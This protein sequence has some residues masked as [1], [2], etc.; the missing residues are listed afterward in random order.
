L[1]ERLRAQSRAS[2]KRAK[3]RRQKAETPKRQKRAFAAQLQSTLNAI[4][5]YTWYATPAGALAFVN[6]RTADYLG[7][8]KDHPLRLGLDTGAAWDSH[9]PLLHPDDRDETRRVWSN[10]LN[11]GSAGE[12]IFRV[13]NAHGEYRWFVSRAEPLRASDGLLLFWTGINLDIDDRKRAEERLR[14]SEAYLAEAQRMTHTGAYSAAAIPPNEDSH[15]DE[16]LP[17][18]VV[19]WSE[20]NYRIWGFDPQH[21]LPSYEALWQRVHPDDRDRA[22]KVLLDA[23]HEKRDYR[24]EARIV[25]PDG[26]IKY[27]EATGHHVFSASGDLVEVI[28]THVDVTERKRAE[29]ALR[30]GEAWLAQAQRLS[31]TSSWIMDATTMRYVYWSDEAYRIW[32]FDPL[33]GPPS[34]EK[35][36]QR[37]HP[38]DLDRCWEEVQEA[39]RQ[40]RDYA[41]EFRILLPDGTVKY[42]ESST[43]HVFS[44][45]GALIEAITTEVDLTE[46]KRAQEEHERLRELESNLAHMNLLRM[47]GELTASLAH[48]ITQPIGSARNN[49]RAA[50]N[51]LGKRPPE[52]DEVSEALGCVVADTD[53]AKN[54]ID[55]IRDQV[56]KAPP[57]KLPFDLNEAIHEVIGLARSAIT[58]NAVWV[59]TRLRE[60]LP[61]VHGDRVQLQQVTLNL[62]LNAV[63]AMGSAQE[64][65]RVLS[66]STEQSQANGVL[67]AVRD[68]GPGIDPEKLERVFD[69]FYTTKS[70]GVGM[71]LSICRSI[72]DAHGGRL[73]ADINEPQGAVFQFTLPSAKNVDSL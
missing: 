47:M 26:T 60:D 49:A 63:E 16:G 24:I 42:L 33:Q 29:E 12:V 40:K 70:G 18:S 50:L 14:R 31:R 44:S 53:R 30:R 52:L 19:Y 45:S 2:G 69:A 23:L 22:R 8:P 13:R 59:Q 20:E 56:K 43:H 54:I 62:I 32:G 66:I 35:K 48:E 27:L 46:R 73:W 41:T 7:L 64:A 37:M 39:V 28:G 36:W 51:F 61:P 71:G 65:Q 57:R 38:D 72:I 67:V 1:V 21:G 15:G 34:R 58:G 10:C 4:P 5:A 55:R 3:A 6:E 17:R 25:L 9:L 11:T 68:S